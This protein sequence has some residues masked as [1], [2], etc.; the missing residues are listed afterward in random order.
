MYVKVVKRFFDILISMLGLALLSWLLLIIS[1][2][3]FIDD[4]GPVFFSQKRVGKDRTFFRLLDML[5]SDA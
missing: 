1:L 3:V 4:P 2:I 5:E